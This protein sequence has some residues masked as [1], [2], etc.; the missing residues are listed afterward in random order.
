MRTGTSAFGSFLKTLINCFWRIFVFSLPSNF[1]EVLSFSSCKTG[2]TPVF[3][4]SLL[5]TCDPNFFKLLFGWIPIFLSNSLF[6]LHII[7]LTLFLALVYACRKFSASETFKTFFGDIHCLCSLLLFRIVLRRTWL[8]GTLPLLFHDGIP[9]S[10]FGTNVFRISW[11]SDLKELHSSSTDL[12][13]FCITNFSV[14]LDNTSCLLIQLESLVLWFYD[15][16]I[17]LSVG[18]NPNSNNI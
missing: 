13:W 18:S 17:F 8:I 6:Y 7:A 2:T 3:V 16:H 15:R 10:C 11:I 4:L 14:Q 5:R 1:V 9:L 12:L